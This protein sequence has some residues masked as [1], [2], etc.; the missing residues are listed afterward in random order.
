MATLELRGGPLDGTVL[1]VPG[2]AGSILV[3]RTM[4]EQPMYRLAIC[5]CCAE[6]EEIL[7]YNFIGYEAN[8]KDTMPAPSSRSSTIAQIKRN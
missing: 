2:N 7:P 6:K 1:S 8:L 3:V 5:K 4:R